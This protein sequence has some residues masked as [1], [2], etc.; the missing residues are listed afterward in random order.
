VTAVGWSR[1]GPRPVTSGCDPFL[2]LPPTKLLRSLGN[3]GA[4]ANVRAVLDQRRRGEWLVELLLHR[5]DGAAAGGAT[6]TAEDTATAHDV[7]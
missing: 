2:V 7:A 6:G 3:D 1:P 4:V 5:L